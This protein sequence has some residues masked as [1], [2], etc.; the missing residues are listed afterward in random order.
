M[1]S[2]HYLQSLYACPLDLASRLS[3]PLSPFFPTKDQQILS[4]S[5]TIIQTEPTCLTIYKKMRYQTKQDLL[6]YRK[7]LQ[8]TDTNS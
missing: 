5:D 8:N 4:M 2:E 3:Q 1:K 6:P 7:T